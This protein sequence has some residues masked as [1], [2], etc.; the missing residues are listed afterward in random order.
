MWWFKRCKGFFCIFSAAWRRCTPGTLNRLWWAAELSQR[1]FRSQ[2]AR[3]HSKQAGAGVTYSILVTQ[4]QHNSQRRGRTWEWVGWTSRDMKK[5]WTYGGGGGLKASSNKAR[6]YSIST[7]SILC[8]LHTHYHLYAP[9]RPNGWF[10]C[11]YHDGK[12]RFISMLDNVM[13]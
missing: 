10:L 13:V 11:N 7:W 12:I 5:T 3:W 4:T 2:H 9:W 8:T 1:G 6:T